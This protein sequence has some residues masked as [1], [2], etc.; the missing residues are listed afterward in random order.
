MYIPLIFLKSS[1]VYSRKYVKL[2][3]TLGKNCNIIT[4]LSHH[5]FFMK[6]YIFKILFSLSRIY[7][8]LYL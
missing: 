3:K 7:I 8:K 2:I 4:R 6:S 1:N 5:Q